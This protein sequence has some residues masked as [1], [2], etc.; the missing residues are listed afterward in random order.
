MNLSKNVG[1]YDFEYYVYIVIY[2]E[3]TY[4]YLLGNS[5]KLAEVE[6]VNKLA[7][8]EFDD[9]LDYEDVDIAR[10]AVHYP[11]YPQGNVSKFVS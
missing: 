4:I 2:Y 8:L 10:D 3:Y 1:I 5:N 7:K 9:E 6:Y 11:R